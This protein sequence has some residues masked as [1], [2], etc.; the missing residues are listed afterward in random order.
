MKNTTDGSVKDE[1]SSNVRDISENSTKEE[2]AHIDNKEKFLSVRFEKLLVSPRNMSAVKTHS[3]FGQSSL[4]KVSL[5][6]IIPKKRR[7]QPLVN[8]SRLENLWRPQKKSP[9]P[10]FTPSQT[11]TSSDSNDNANIFG[12]KFSENLENF[13]GLTLEE[14]DGGEQGEGRTQFASNSF[15]TINGCSTGKR[16]RCNSPPKEVPGT[17]SPPSS[18]GQQARLLTSD[19]TADE[20]AGYLEDTSFFPKRM[21]HMAEMM[22]T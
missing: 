2:V 15:R 14:E 10:I 1:D 21:S 19:V 6:K 13:A 8:P 17:E 4:E 7:K 12:R 20:L 5:R 11:L 9:E 16:K 3:A 18:C 22:Y